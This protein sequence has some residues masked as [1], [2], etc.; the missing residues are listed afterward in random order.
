VIE[1][2]LSNTSSPWGP[3]LLAS[4]QVLSTTE[5]PFHVVGSEK[6]KPYFVFLYKIDFVARV[7]GFEV[8]CGVL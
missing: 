3:L 7:A 6:V 8:V 2:P 1:G 4:F 5:Y